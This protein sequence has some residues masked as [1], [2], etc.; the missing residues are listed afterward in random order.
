ML[1][2]FIALGAVVRISGMQVVFSLVVLV[3]GKGFERTSQIWRIDKWLQ[4][5]Y[6]GQGFGYLNHGTSFEK[7]HLLWSD[8]VHL[9]DEGKS[10]FGHRLAKL[11]K[12]AL[13]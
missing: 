8:G 2:D 13:N 11:A 7:P 3:K 4:G 12:N 10:I 5:W 9:S 6:H 1:K